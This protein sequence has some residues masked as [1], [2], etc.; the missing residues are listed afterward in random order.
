MD[1]PNFRKA[2]GELPSCGTCEHFSAIGFCGRYQRPMFSHELCDSF[3]SVL[4][5]PVRP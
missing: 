2:V 5:T 3:V 1:P 4:K